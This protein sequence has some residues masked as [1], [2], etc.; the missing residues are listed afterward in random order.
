MTAL[1]GLA[2]L[3]HLGVG[4]ADTVELG[5]FFVV[6]LLGGAHCLGM[7]G[8]LVT[9]Y[10]DRM[11]AQ[12]TDGGRATGV[13]SNQG[14]RTG[15]KG[16]VL[17]LY[18]VRQHALFNLGRTVSYATIGA[19]FGLAGAV[20][21]DA[22]A[23]T[24][25]EQPIR[26]VTGFVVAL[27]ILL[28]GVRYLLGNFGGHSFLGSGAF[29]WIYARIES[30]VDDWATG[31]GI[32]GFGLVHGFLPCPLLYP[33]FLY[34]FAQGSPLGGAVSLALLGLGTFPT[35]FLYGTLIQSV[36]A[37]NRARLHRALGVGFLVMGWMLLSHSLGLVGIEV[38]H[39][40]IPIYQ[41]L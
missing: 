2:Q 10:A 15:G 19:A 16:D 25:Y 23:L 13:G 4:G 39:V 35:L 34:V 1:D 41:P 11:N 3:V 21:F 14:A 17:T 5:V 38:P 12:R 18:E 6:G 40:E 9:M 24:Q 28:S 26:F 36:G 29:S 27:V 22:S 32:F 33:A 8:P 30:K 20:L 7:C 37:T 31:P